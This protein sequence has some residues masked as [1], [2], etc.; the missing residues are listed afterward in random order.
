MIKKIGFLN[1]KKQ[2][3]LCSAVLA[4]FMLSACQKAGSTVVSAETP[5]ETPVETAAEVTRFD[6]VFDADAVKR[7]M[8]VWFLATKTGTDT[9]SGD[10]T[11]VKTP[12]GKYIL[13]DGS[14]PETVHQ[15]KSYFDALGVTELEAIIATHPHIDH[16]GG[17]TQIIYQLPVNK[18]YR[19]N[20]EYPTNTNKMFLEAIEAKGIETVILKEGMVIEI[21]GVKIDIF[22][23]TETVIYPKGFPEGSTAFI[24]DHSIVAKFTYKESTLLLPGDLYVSGESSV[25]ERFGDK[26]QS[27]VMKMS[28]HGDDTSNTPTFIKT[29][30]PMIAVAEFDRLASLNVYNSYR[31]NGA[32]AF[33]TA[34][35]GNVRV[36][37]DGTKDYKVLTEKDRIGDFLK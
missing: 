33:I 19:S 24:N 15:L 6:E 32:K 25:L 30:K 28:H 36:I 2:I 1:R 21:D 31:K 20:V 5:V 23:P 35:D 7:N 3:A 29:I 10:S 8:A 16:V 14:A 9:K 27:D 4:L 12:S 26:L 11:L 34:I 37:M 22:N 17:L 18:V 13:I